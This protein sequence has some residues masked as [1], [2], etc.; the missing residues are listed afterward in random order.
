[1]G[2]TK[3]EWAKYT[4]NAWIGCDK[5]SAECKNCYAEQYAKRFLSSEDLWGKG[6]DRHLTADSNWKKPLQWNRIA[7]EEGKIERVF[8]NSLSDWAENNPALT[9]W[10]ERLFDLIRATPNLVWLLLTK[11]YDYSLK[12][13]EMLYWKGTLPGNIMLGFT[14]GTPRT[15][16]HAMN[17]MID[18]CFNDGNGFTGRCPVLLNNLKIFLSCEPLLGDVSNDLFEGL[19][20][21]LPVH[22]IIIGG[23]SGDKA[24]PMDPQW[25]RS[26]IKIG[27]KNDIPVMFKQWGEWVGGTI[28][29]RKGKVMLDDGHIFWT[30]PGHPKLRYWRNKGER[31]EVSAKVGKHSKQLPLMDKSVK[32]SD[33]RSF[34]GRHFDELYN[35]ELNGKT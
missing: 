3:I 19:E 11:R 20:A 22:E 26:L 31:N 34:Q 23:E 5:V 7:G 15:M 12:Y 32:F 9:M 18:S 24:R 6:S 30:N 2:I 14:T 29:V 8:S 10:R 33:N 25:V 17:A 16:K 1:M 35:F 28:D 13:L 21:G 27:K 4:F